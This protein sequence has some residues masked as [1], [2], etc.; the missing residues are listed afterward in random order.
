MLRREEEVVFR[1]TPVAQV[2]PGDVIVNDR[3]ASS[4]CGHRHRVTRVSAGG[5]DV[6]V[7]EFEEGPPIARLR[8][9]FVT[10]LAAV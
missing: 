9:E 3:E 6:V 10:R 1:D 4:H 7:L 5:E 8:H 2:A